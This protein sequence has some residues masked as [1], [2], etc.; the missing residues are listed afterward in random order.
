[1]S[2]RIKQ[3]AAA[4]RQRKI[5]AFLVTKD[6]N[7][8]Y[9]TG[10]CACESWLLVTLSRTSY[11]TDSRFVQEAREGLKGIDVKCTKESMVK[12]LAEEIEK[13]GVKRIGIDT[14]NL[15][16]FQYRMLRR[17]CPKG[18]RLV[19]ADNLVEELRAVKDRKEIQKIRNALGVHKLAHQFIKRNIRPNIKE[20]ELLFQLER[21]VKSKNASFAFDPIIASGPNSCY[22]HAKVTERRIRNNEPLLIDM[23]IDVEGYKSDLTRMFFLGKI[24]ALVRQVFDAVN[25]ARRCAIAEIRAGV[26]AAEIDYSARNYLEKQKLEKY[27]GHALG[28]GVGLEV[29]E[30]PRLA[31]NDS[32]VLKEGMVI[33]VEPAVYLPGRFG[34]RLEDMVLVG[35]NDCEILSDD[36][37]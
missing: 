37:H 30:S 21:F 26:A 29:H 11:I 12:T 15:T 5:D 34:V 25:E 6:V 35:K 18:V 1:M 13:G 16:L 10:F 24:P 19:K 14:R 4:F 7:I 17:N 28:H 33:T 23:G 27:F 3:L 31:H 9:L 2:T 20:N 22:P 8:T 36:I 32:T